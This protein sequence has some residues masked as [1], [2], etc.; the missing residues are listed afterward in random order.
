MQGLDKDEE[1]KTRAFL[2]GEACCPPME[3]NSIP[4]IPEDLGREAA[5]KLLDEINRGG[6]V[7]SAF[8]SMTALF[9]ALGKKNVSKAL[10]GPLTQ[11]T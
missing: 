7:D 5:M 8:Q 6:C 11:S 2:T 10:F 1:N 3:T 9:M 4:C